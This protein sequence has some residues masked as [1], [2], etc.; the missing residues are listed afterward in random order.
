MKEKKETVLLLCT[1]ENLASFRDSYQNNDKYEFE[2]IFNFST[3]NHTKIVLD[4]SC[5]NLFLEICKLFSSLLKGTKV[6]LLCNNYSDLATKYKNLYFENC[7]CII[8]DKQ[9]IYEKQELL[10][11]FLDNDFQIEQN[12]SLLY[13]YQ[14][15]I[16]NAPK[17][18]YQKDALLKLIEEDRI[19]DFFEIMVEFQI[20]S[21][22][23]TVISLSREFI[24]NKVGH[25]FYDRLKVLVNQLPSE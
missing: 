15:I 5:I 8:I 17:P 2:T 14:N 20:P 11:R 21:I 4:E 6:V 22:Q 7:Q 10:Y 24:T 16:E 19:P 3:K 12:K 23:P 9:L 25:N 13:C 1:E 18:I